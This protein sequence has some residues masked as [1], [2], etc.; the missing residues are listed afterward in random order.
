MAHPSMTAFASSPSTSISQSP[1]SR[2][3]TAPKVAR[4]EA[5]LIAL[6]IDAGY[7]V[8]GPR[9]ALYDNPNTRCPSS[10]AMRSSPIGSLRRPI[11]MTI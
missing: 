10:A 4:L 3:V 11:P 1:P 6:V 7:A 5:E 9:L 2:L 8:T